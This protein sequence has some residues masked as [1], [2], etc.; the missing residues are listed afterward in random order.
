MVDAS[1]GPQE[2]QGTGTVE[3]VR[4]ALLADGITQAELDS[5]CDAMLEARGPQEATAQAWQ[6]MDTRSPLAEVF[7]LVVPKTAEETY[8]DT[9]GRPITSGAEPRT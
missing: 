7:W 6:P 3:D 1:R 4:N 5:V 9:S 2:L 8:T